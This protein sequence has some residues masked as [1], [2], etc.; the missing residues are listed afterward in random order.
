VSSYP[1][2]PDIYHTSVISHS[3]AHWKSYRR[4]A[5]ELLHLP[6]SKSVIT[7]HI[8][9]PFWNFLWGVCADPILSSWAPCPELCDPTTAGVR[10]IWVRRNDLSVPESLGN[11]TL[12]FYRIIGNNR[13]S[14]WRN[15]LLHS[16]ASVNSTNTYI[17]G[18]DNRTTWFCIWFQSCM[19]VM[20]SH[21]ETYTGTF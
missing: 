6:N 12:S 5:L 3:V 17:G 10:G 18:C 19:W 16:F 8:S 1:D 4:T 13:G 20:C 2:P 11:F 9:F 21:T 15:S 14:L 7:W